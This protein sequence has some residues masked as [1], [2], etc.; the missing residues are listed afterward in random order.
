MINETIN[1]LMTRRSVRKFRPDQIEPKILKEILE[2]GT[3]AP[4]GMNKQSPVIVAVQSPEDRQ[5]VMEL[6]K[7]ARGFGG[8]PYYGAPTILL[9][10]ADS[11]ITDT[12]V[13]DGSCVLNTMMTAAHAL[14]AATCWIHGEHLMFDLSEGKALL[15]KWG[16]PEGLRGVG[17]LALGYAEGELPAPKPRKEGY[18][19]IV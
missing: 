5:A 11:G 6:N 16:L 13:E 2:A 1:I 12:Y 17:A 19:K 8:D 4:T 15:K 18:F 7:K 10:L 9:V 3:Y 14:G